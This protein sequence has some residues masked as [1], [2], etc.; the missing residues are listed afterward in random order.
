MIDINK[1]SIFTVIGDSMNNGS[2]KGFINGDILTCIETNFQSIEV[3]HYYV[4]QYNGNTL[5]RQ[6]TRC[7]GE[8]LT[9]TPLNSS[10]NEHELSKSDIL[11]IY[12]VEQIQRKMCE[13]D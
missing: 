7:D 12:S 10:Y 9:A 13:F 4:I 2:N 5:V 3:G 6:V 8:H 1:A 11:H